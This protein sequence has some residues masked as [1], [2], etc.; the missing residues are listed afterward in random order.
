[1]ADSTKLYHDAIGPMYNEV[2]ADTDEVRQKYNEIVQAANDLVAAGLDLYNY[3]RVD[4]TTPFQAVQAGAHPATP[5]N[6]NSLATTAWTR[7]RM[8]EYLR[9]SMSSSGAAM[10]GPLYLSG[11]PTQPLMAATKSYVDAVLGAGGTMNASVTIVA[12][13]PS[14]RLRSTS[15]NENR[16]FEALSVDGL[17]RWVLTLADQSPLGANNQGAN[18]MLARYT[19]TG[20]LID[21]PIRIDRSNGMVQVRADPTA[22]L[23]V[24]TKQYVDNGRVAGGVTTV[25]GNRITTFDAGAYGAG[26]TFTP[27][28][29]NSN[30][31]LYRNV[32]AHTLAAPAADC[33]MD[34]MVYNQSPGAITFSGYNVGPNTGDLLTLTVGHWFIISIRRLWGISTYVIKALQ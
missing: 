34:I 7:G 5:S 23:H 8:N 16:N 13:N 14:V 3:V 24:A 18:F 33:A 25:G 1:M 15:T 19:D 29:F 21:Y 10:T 12:S 6:D 32:G 27:N 2:V 20:A 28:A 22:A 11:P 17:Q 31:Q 30:Y 4:G 26:Q 9:D